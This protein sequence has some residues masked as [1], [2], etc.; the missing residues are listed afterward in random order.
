MKTRYRL[1]CLGSR[2]GTCYCFVSKTGK[3]VSLQTTAEEST[4]Q[5][6][7]AQNNAARQLEM[8]LQI[9][10]IYLRHDAPALA[11]HIWLAVMEQIIST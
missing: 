3:R 9:A 11:A 2:G 7:E 6:A 5:L 10:Q 4:Q 8:N 1:P